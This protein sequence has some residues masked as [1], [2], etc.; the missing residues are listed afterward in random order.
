MTISTDR[1]AVTP[2]RVLDLGTAYQS[3][4]VLL[5]AVELGVFSEL[6]SGPLTLTELISKLGLHQRAARDFL[7]TLVALQLL[8]RDGVTYRNTV[9]AELFLNRSSRMYLG[10]I[11]EMSNER[12]YPFWGRLTE[13]LITGRPQNESRDGGDFFA[14]LYDDQDRLR[15]FI[16]AMDA[17]AS[18]MGAAL[19]RIVPWQGYES[20][21]DVGG[22]RGGV[23]AQI[24]KAHPHLRAGCFDLP[25]VEPVF[26]EH[27]QR[28][29]TTSRVTFHPGDFFVDP[30]PSTDVI[31][32]GHVL[33]DWDAAQKA[34]LIDKAYRALKPGGAVLIYDAM[35]DEDRRH[36]LFGLLMSLNMLIETAG[37]Y[38]YTAT[39]CQ[40]LMRAVGFVNCTSQPLIGP[41]TLVIGHKPASKTL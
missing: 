12:L 15:D 5:S 9:E 13:A 32:L 11:L 24:A 6:A 2:Q 33:H 7:D 34:L 10:G 28:L 36:N 19:T 31:V 29:E 37:G 4:K 26:V 1:P 3:S 35:I 40:S 38:E 18:F 17:S 14:A 25:P 22:A 21:V 16:A 20:F 39:E 27:M 30:L 23:A 41:D 8:D